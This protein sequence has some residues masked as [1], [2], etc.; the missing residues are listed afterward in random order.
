MRDLDNNDGYDYGENFLAV[1]AG[2]N[3]WLG[4]GAGFGIGG[5]WYHYC[6]TGDMSKTAN[7]V[8]DSVQVGAYFEVW[9][10]N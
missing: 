4:N 7:F 9:L 10:G 5:A 3:L 6:N 8:K 2:W 1:K